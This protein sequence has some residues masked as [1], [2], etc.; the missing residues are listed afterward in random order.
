MVP[1]LPIGP[2]R[3]DLQHAPFLWDMKCDVSQSVVLGD[4]TCQLTASPV[5]AAARLLLQ[6]CKDASH[7]YILFINIIYHCSLDRVL[8]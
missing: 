5:A 4:E 3:E 6:D 7:L 8:A 2:S 1:T